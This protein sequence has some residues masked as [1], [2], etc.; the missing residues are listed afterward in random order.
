MCKGTGTKVGFSYVCA[1]NN[2]P[3]ETYPTKASKQ[4]IEPENVI[5]STK[6]QIPSRFKKGEESKQAAFSQ[7]GSLV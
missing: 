6:L 7:V 3:S 1:K 2:F 5:V 4:G